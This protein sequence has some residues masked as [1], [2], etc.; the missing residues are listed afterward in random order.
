M[1]LSRKQ[2]PKQFL[3]IEGERSLLEATIERLSPVVDP[4]HT[5]VVT[6]AEHARG[7]AYQSLDGLQKLMEPV[8]RNTAPA[9]AVTVPVATQSRRCPASMACPAARESRVTDL[10]NPNLSSALYSGGWHP[11]LAPRGPTTVGN[12]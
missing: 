6:G 1:A 10:S 4:D 11:S 9:I 12:A 3:N 5:L 8:G 7:E 2:L